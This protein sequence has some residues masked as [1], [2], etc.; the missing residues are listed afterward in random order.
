MCI[1]IH[2][3]LPTSE[4]EEETELAG[5]TNRQSQGADLA[6]LLAESE[7]FYAQAHLRYRSFIGAVDTEPPPFDVSVVEKVSYWYLLPR[8][9]DYCGKLPVY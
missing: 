4:D 8:M 2:R 7:Q 9:V 6:Q 3:S 5:D 1:V